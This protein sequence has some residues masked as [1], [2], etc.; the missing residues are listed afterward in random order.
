[1]GETAPNSKRA[2]S[3]LQLPLCENQ[4]H[5]DQIKKPRSY[6][7]GRHVSRRHVCERVSHTCGIGEVVLAC[8]KGRAL[9][10]NGSKDRQQATLLLG[11]EQGDGTAG[12]RQST[13]Y[14]SVRPLE[15]TQL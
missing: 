9:M 12:I 10:R 1:M 14:G 15:C 4:R 3:A 6:L 8:L 5:I 7:G 2:Q 11:S 13:F